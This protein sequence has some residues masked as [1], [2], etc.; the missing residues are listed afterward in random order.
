MQYFSAP[1]L[2]VLVWS[3]HFCSSRPWFLGFCVVGLEQDQCSCDES[4]VSSPIDVPKMSIYLPELESVIH[5]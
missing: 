2:H 5:S 1:E 4:F 3:C